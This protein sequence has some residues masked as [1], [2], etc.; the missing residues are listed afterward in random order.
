VTHSGLPDIRRLVRGGML[1]LLDH[2]RLG[3]EVRKLINMADQPSPFPQ[4][5]VRSR[6]FSRSEFVISTAFAAAGDGVFDA[7][8]IKLRLDNDTSSNTRVAVVCIALLERG[9][10]ART[11]SSALSRC[12]DPA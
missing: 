7:R 9:L 12:W 10:R 6:S 2:C 1:P 8:R 11:A 3:P 4:H 5:V